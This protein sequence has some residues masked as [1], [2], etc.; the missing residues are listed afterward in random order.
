VSLELGDADSFDSFSVDAPAG[1]ALDDLGTTRAGEPEEIDVPAARVRSLAKDLDLPD[2]WFAAFD[3][4]LAA[5]APY[6]WYDE[7]A[8]TVRAHVVRA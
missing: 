3:S 5:V 8:D 1:L 7:A 4:M 6:G 2:E